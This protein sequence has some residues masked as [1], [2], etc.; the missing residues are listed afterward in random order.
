M[1]S[2]SAAPQ[3]KRQGFLPV[4]MDCVTFIG[5]CISLWGIGYMGFSGAW[6]A[7]GSVGYFFIKLARS[8]RAK[9]TSSLKAIGENEK[10]FIIQNFSVRDLPSWVYFPDV[11]RAE[12]LNKVIKRLWPY[13]CDYAT[14]LIRQTV[15]PAVSAQ[16]PSALLPFDFLTLDLG[17]TP[18]RIGGVKVYMEESIRRDE[19]VLDLDLML[20]SDARI[21]VQLGNVKAGV[22]EFELRGTMRVVMKPLVPKVPFAGAVTVCF[23]DSPYIHFALTDIG[24]ILSLPGLQQT[25]NTVI[26]NVVDELIVLPNRLPVQLLDNV[27]IQR[28]KYPMPQGVLRVNVIGA[29][30]LKIG[31]KNL[32][33]GG[34]SDPYCVIR[35]GARTFQTAVIQHT[36][37]PEWNE[38][39]EVIV[40]V[41]QGQSL[42]IEVLD[43]DQGNK[44]D[45]LGRTSIPLSS[46]HELGEMDTWTPLE[47]VKTGSIHLKLA[48]LALSDN[49]DDLSQ[50]AEQASVYR[51]AF[52]V[53][54][55]A[56]F[57]Y[58][59]VEQAKNL[60]LL[61]HFQTSL[62]PELRSPGANVVATWSVFWI[63][64]QGNMRVKQMREPSPFC[65]LLL[66][67]EA[68]KTGP[69]PYT[70]SP[71][72]DS[73]HHFLVGDP[74]VD[75]LQIIVRDARGEELLGR[76]S[77]PIKLLI[78]EQN[79]SVTRPF[80][81]EECGPETATIHLHLELKALVPRPKVEPV[82]LNN[83]EEEDKIEDANQVNA[84]D[85]RSELV[86]NALKTDE[87]T[88]LRQRT[89]SPEQPPFDQVQ[90]E[91]HKSWQQKC[92]P[93]E[94][95]DMKKREVSAS[96]ERTNGQQLGNI[97][98]T[99]EYR[100]TSSLLSVIVHE[101]SN[102]R[103]VDKDGL[104]DP[105]V[106][107]ALVDNNGQVWGEKK[108][109]SPVKNSL[110]PIYEAS[111]DFDVSVDQLPSHGLLI[112]VRNRVS[113][114]TRSGRTH[115]MGSVYIDLCQFVTTET[116]SDWFP[117]IPANSISM[118]DHHHPSSD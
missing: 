60:K 113:L 75:T 68:Q 105:Y 109:T 40:D 118:C 91:M 62:F 54:M 27:D 73:V 36:L 41:W 101:A 18:P 9:L 47:E 56:C 96:P 51:A 89:R 11:E 5:S 23:L 106:V 103:G 102:L 15:A 77:I 114:F 19:V 58:V 81:L 63:A 86:G 57:L 78:S 108:K 83:G 30:R 99:V 59:V 49:P 76:C 112:E 32:I 13:I 12:W 25:L 90:L 2:A 17:D 107:V 98:L 44:D 53:A 45:F 3:K 116:L 52:G 64:F 46:V 48:W 87:D 42:A 50:S 66:G 94:S 70:Q 33:T 4:A 61:F 100:A 115:Q 20:Y 24:N 1:L 65:N 84:V 88:V 55:S 34:S 85:P 79:M 95:P 93:E 28:L 22:K 111:F 43:K 38:Q 74:Y 37:E 31:D 8:R 117:L 10:Q 69:K 97:K 16:L 92:T 104:A 29:R 72:W 80:T 110:N 7:L 26:R 82:E 67:R 39:F 71:T 21:R 14:D 6:V 35:V